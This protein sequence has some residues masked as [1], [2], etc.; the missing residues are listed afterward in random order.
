MSGIMYRGTAT[1]YTILSLIRE[2]IQKALG[3][4]WAF[5]SNYTWQVFIYSALC[6]HYCTGKAPWGLCLNKKDIYS[7]LYKQKF[8]FLKLCGVQLHCAKLPPCLGGL[9]KQP[10]SNGL[11]YCGHFW[12]GGITGQEGEAL[13]RDFPEDL[14][15]WLWCSHCLPTAHWLWSRLQTAESYTYTHYYRRAT[16][17]LQASVYTM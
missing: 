3:D 7:Y 6:S 15:P 4:G 17:R 11:I 2:H 5:L 13:A 14:P 8:S 12:G 1:T 9:G 10:S 16:A